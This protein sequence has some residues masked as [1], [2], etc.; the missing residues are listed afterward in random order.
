MAAL[1]FAGPS[2][3]VPNERWESLVRVLRSLL[4]AG[5][6]QPEQ[7]GIVSPYKA[8]VNLLQKLLG[9]DAAAQRAPHNHAEALGALAACLEDRDIELRLSALDC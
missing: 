3:A 9:S 6:V 8:Q 5:E 7:V 2:L 4:E 1:C